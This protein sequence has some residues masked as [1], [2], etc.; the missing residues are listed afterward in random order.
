MKHYGLGSERPNEKCYNEDKLKD[1][2]EKY[3][4]EKERPEQAKV[5]KTKEKKTEKQKQCTYLS[6]NEFF[7]QS[8]RGKE[9]R[10]R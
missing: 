7:N 10:A 4:K 8:I 6:R 9:L 1:R 5:K 2:N 3:K